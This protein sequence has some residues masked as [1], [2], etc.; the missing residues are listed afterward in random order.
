MSAVAGKILIVY[1]VTFLILELLFKL[2]MKI[3]CILW[4]EVPRSLTGQNS[5]SGP[6]ATGK[7][8][9][10]GNRIDVLL[11]LKK[12]NGGK[13]MFDLTDWLMCVY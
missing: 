9:K 12:K 10:R 6:Y 13:A 4:L 7:D 2:D 5:Y 11:A 8:Y 3:F 1:L